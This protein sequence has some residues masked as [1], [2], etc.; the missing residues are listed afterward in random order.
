M[1]VYENYAFAIA[2]KAVDEIASGYIY[3]KPHEKSCEFCKYSSICGHE[4]VMGERKL[5]KVENF[6]GIKEDE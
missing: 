1:S 2:N 6:K 3:P 4:N 5:L